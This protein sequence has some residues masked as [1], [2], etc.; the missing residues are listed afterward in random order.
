LIA[1]IVSVFTRRAATDLSGWVLRGGV[2]AFFIMQGTD[3]FPSGPH[4]PWVRFFQD[5]GIGQWFRYFTGVVEIVG[6]I[7]YFLPWTCGIG[8]LLL[9][10][11]MI[12]AISVM[13]AMGHPFAGFYPGLVLVALIAIAL[14]EPE[15]SPQET[16]RRMFSRR[17]RPNY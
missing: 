15:A 7:L 14:R 3:K 6:A 10:C 13:A 1:R 12:G 2:A 4:E 9:S 16:A 5:V 11:T 8:M 17:T